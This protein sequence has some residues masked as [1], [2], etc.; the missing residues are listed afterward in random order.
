MFVLSNKG[1]NYRHH[2]YDIDTLEDLLMA[3]T[4]DKTETKR[5]TNIAKNMRF[6]DVFHNDY[7]YLKCKEED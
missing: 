5:L 3:V 6:G 2:L 4:G 1:S 7:I